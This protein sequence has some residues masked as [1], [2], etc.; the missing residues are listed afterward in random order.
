MERIFSSKKDDSE[1]GKID[2][3]ESSQDPASERKKLDDRLARQEIEYEKLDAD[4]T[5]KDIRNK[6]LDSE[7]DS[8]IILQYFTTKFLRENRSFFNDRFMLMGEMAVE[9]TQN[10]VTE[11]VYGK[12]MFP[13]FF[14]RV[15]DKISGTQDNK[16]LLFIN[17]R[18]HVV[19]MPFEC[20]SKDRVQI[21]GVVFFNVRFTENDIPRV[22][23][24]LDGNLE[25]DRYWEDKGY[26]GH[27][28]ELSLSDIERVLKHQTMIEI[29][30]R[31]MVKYD[32]S[33]ILEN[34]IKINEEITKALNDSSVHWAIRGLQVDVTQVDI[35]ENAY[36]EVIEKKAEL[37]RLSLM[38]EIQTDAEIRKGEIDKDKEKQL[39]RFNAEL[40]IQKVVSSVELGRAELEGTSE[41]NEIQRS[42]QFKKEAEELNQK[43]KM[44]LVQAEGNDKLQKLTIET[45]KYRDKYENEKLV[46]SDRL[47]R[48]KYKE[49]EQAKYE[50]EKRKADG[51]VDTFDKFSDVHNKRAELIARQ[52]REQLTLQ[53]EL[54]EARKTTDL[55]I[56]VAEK[57]A[58]N[59]GYR[60]GQRDAR[61]DNLSFNEMQAK[62]PQATHQ[63]SYGMPPSPYA[64][65]QMYY[66]QSA[67]PAAPQQNGTC[68]ECEANLKAGKR[69][70]DG[71]G[72]RLV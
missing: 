47:E 15:W 16:A 11:K 19:Q 17:L 5:E 46:E 32:S 50:A 54:E 58:Y 53:T 66:Q 29:D 9:L 63:P 65:Q 39:I 59:T 28:K 49:W 25:R 36:N 38:Y 21:K 6:K 61:E 4:A 52:E 45:S 64:P 68:P 7:R 22:M 40:E 31:V 48:D 23:T 12:K 10:E 8:E 60:D 34:R 14:K 69:F 37:R 35:T 71:C 41:L 26:C 56:Q 3:V 13:G 2:K 27:V 33:E 18:P 30:Q 24:F 42:E 1:K 72:K 43:I 62:N 51:E 57:E 20:Y 70:C 44:G 55:R 67:P